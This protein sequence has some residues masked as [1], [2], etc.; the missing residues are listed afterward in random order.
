MTE[1]LADPGDG[2]SKWTKVDKSNYYFVQ[3]NSDNTVETNIYGR[4]ENALKY[5]NTDSSLSL[6]Y[7]GGDSILLYYKIEDPYLTIT[8][9]CYEA[10]GSKFKTDL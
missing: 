2:S 5:K 9:G 7:S 4:V 6:I 3:F 8:G 1:T 10:C